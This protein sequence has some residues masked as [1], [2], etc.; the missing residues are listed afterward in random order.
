MLRRCAPISK[1]LTSREMMAEMTA[2][3]SVWPIEQAAMNPA[4]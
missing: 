3:S 4:E 1:T 2:A